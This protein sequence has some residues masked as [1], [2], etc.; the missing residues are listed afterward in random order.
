MI[1]Y[2]LSFLTEHKLHE[3]WEVLIYVGL[4]RKWGLI[5]KQKPEGTSLTKIGSIIVLKL[6]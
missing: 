1:I 5:L 4:S 6:N 2:Y 3:G